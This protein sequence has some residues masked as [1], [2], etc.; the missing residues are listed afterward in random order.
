MLPHR[1]SLAELGG[2]ATSIVAAITAN[3]EQAEHYLRVGASVVAM[4]VGIATIYSIFR[5]KK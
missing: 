3:Q 5:K 4:A 1:L 2:A